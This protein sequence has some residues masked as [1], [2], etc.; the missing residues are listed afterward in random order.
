MWTFLNTE[1][2][3]PEPTERRLTPADEEQLQDMLDAGKIALE[4][5]Q[6]LKRSLQGIYASLCRRPEQ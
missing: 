6:K 2:G 4:I 1:S 5:S 3:K